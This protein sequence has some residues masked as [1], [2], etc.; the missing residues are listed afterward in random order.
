MSGARNWIEGPGLLSTGLYG[1]L[2]VSPIH[3]SK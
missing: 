1:K 2:L 3:I